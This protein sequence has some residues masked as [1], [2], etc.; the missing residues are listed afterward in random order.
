V[1]G[2]EDAPVSCRQIVPVCSPIEMRFNGIVD[3]KGYNGIIEFT[4]PF[5]HEYKG[6][7]SNGVFNGKKIESKKK[8]MNIR[9]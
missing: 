3:K 2:L 5:G 7:L 1:R 8:K 9:G 4:A 6:H